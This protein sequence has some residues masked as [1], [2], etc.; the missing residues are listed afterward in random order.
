MS[1]WRREMHPQKGVIIHHCD[2]HNFHSTELMEIE[3]H[4]RMHEIEAGGFKY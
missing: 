3:E 2:K 4:E 1:F